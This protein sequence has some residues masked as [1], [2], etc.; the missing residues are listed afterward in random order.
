MS[1]L[2][3]FFSRLDPG[4]KAPPPEI[5]AAPSHLKYIGGVQQSRPVG[6]PLKKILEDDELAHLGTTRI[7]EMNAYSL[8]PLEDKRKRIMDVQI[9]QI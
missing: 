5:I 9:K 3:K 6:R 7:G 8:L 4:S 2:T 1:F